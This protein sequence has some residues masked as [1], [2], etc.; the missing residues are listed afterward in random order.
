MSTFF[1]I[2][3]IVVCSIFIV[4]LWLLL[5]YRDK[6]QTNLGLNQEDHQKLQL[7]AERAEKLQDRVRTL[8]RILDVESPNW[9][10]S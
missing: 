2:I 8:E 9:R 7:L 10:Q 3:T 6:K 1:I 4:P 5:H